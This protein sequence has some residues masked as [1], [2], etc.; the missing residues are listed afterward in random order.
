[1]DQQV[2]KILERGPSAVIEAEAAWYIRE[3][4]LTFS[5]P[6]HD[7]FLLGVTFAGSSARHSWKKTDEYV[8]VQEASRSSFASSGDIPKPK[9]PP[10]ASAAPK[11]KSAARTSGEVS[12]AEIREWAQRE[13]HHVNERGRISQEIKDLF[14]A[15]RK[16]AARAARA[17][18]S[19]AKGATR[20]APSTRRAQRAAAAPSTSSSE[21]VTTRR[22]PR[23]IVAPPAD[24]PDA[25]PSRR[26]GRPRSDAP[27]TPGRR[28]ASPSSTGRINRTVVG[29]ADF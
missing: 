16:A 18:G 10:K 20:L 4:D 3:A 12:P 26:V 28:T 23:H 5:R 6:A 29:E 22:R 27:A 24:H 19:A 13:G 17:E 21:Q 25:Q 1:V 11:P 15:A 8:D 9:V 7:A 2:A 14:Y